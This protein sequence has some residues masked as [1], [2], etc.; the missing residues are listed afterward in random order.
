MSSV[1]QGYKPRPSNIG[2]YCAIVCLDEAWQDIRRFD[3]K[4]LPS[5]LLS[6]QCADA[7]ALDPPMEFAGDS[8]RQKQVA[9]HSA[10]LQA[11]N[12]LDARHKLAVLDL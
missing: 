11:L 10:A 9:K 6:Q 3:K 5:I 8:F 4:M 1:A 2:N 12:Y 7:E